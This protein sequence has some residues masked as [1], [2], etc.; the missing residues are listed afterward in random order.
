LPDPDFLVLQSLNDPRMN[1]KIILFPHELEA[2]LLAIARDV[3]F[4]EA[5]IR[6]CSVER[7]VHQWHAR[8]NRR[9]VERASRLLGVSLE[10]ELGAQTM[11]LDSV[12]VLTTLDDG[13]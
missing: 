2:L 10:S 4:E 13:G 6:R 8:I 5:S 9:F 3:G 7:Q 11:K 1:E 12:I